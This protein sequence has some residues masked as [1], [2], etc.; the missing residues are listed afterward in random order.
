MR[1]GFTLIEMMV[2]VAIL[3]TLTVMVFPSVKP[4]SK[5]VDVAMRLANLV[6]IAARDAVRWGPVRSDIATTEGSKRRTRITASVSGGQVTFRA[7]VL[8]D[9]GTLGVWRD[10]GTY[11]VPKTITSD[12]YL[13]SVNSRASLLTSWA[14]LAIS[15]FPNGTCSSTTASGGP[16]ASVF[17]S[18]T[19]GAAKD[20]LARMS[21]LPL[22]G[23]T[24]VKNNE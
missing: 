3:L 11:T 12:G 14:S 5:P 19:T 24:Y 15:C 16:G 4:Q 2:V 1:R 8:D 7:Q 23:T 17:F 20:R 22:G 9:T 13:N 21:V 10:L 18:S 6:D